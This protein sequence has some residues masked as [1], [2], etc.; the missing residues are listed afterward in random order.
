MTILNAAL[1]Y[2]KGGRRIFP[3]H[4]IR[5][6]TCACGGAKNCKA[7]KHPIGALAPRGV[8]DA[9]ADFATI[10]S[11]WTR[12]PDANIGI[13]TGKASDLVVLDV[14]G[15]N[16][17]AFLAQLERKHGPL[18]PTCEVKTGKGRHLYFRYPE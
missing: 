7:G 2:A 5:N 9:T 10:T 4:S 16:G 18:P 13:A 12:V 6:G 17:E 1:T 11:W 15:L 3:V 8:L 14:D